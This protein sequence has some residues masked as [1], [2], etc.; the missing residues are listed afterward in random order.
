[1]EFEESYECECPYCNEKIK[2]VIKDIKKKVG[3]EKNE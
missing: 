1:M 3:V 2:V